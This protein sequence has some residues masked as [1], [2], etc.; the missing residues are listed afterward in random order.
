MALRAAGRRSHAPIRPRPLQLGPAHVGHVLGLT[1][2]IRRLDPAFVVAW[3]ARAVLATAL[4]GRAVAGRPSRPARRPR[5]HGNPRR[6]AA[7]ASAS[8]RPRT[9]SPTSSR[10]TRWCCI[11]AST[12]PASPRSRSPRALRTRLCLGALVGWKRPELALEIAALMPELRLT[13]AGATLPG[14]DGAL[15]A[16]AAQPGRPTRGP[17]HDRPRRRRAGP[18]SPPPTSCST[19]PTPSPTA[20][21]SSRRWPRA[22]R[23][24]PR[25][26]RARSRSSRTAR[27]VSTRPATP[28]AAVE[29]LRAVLADAAR[30]RG[31]PPP[32]RERLRRRR[33]RRAAW[34]ALLAVTFA[35]VIVLHESRAELA[36]LLD[37]LHSTRAAARR[38]RHRPRR[39]RGRNSRENTAR[40]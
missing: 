31:R 10:R 29:A 25:P 26:R 11:P 3:G 33:L 13:L 21:P 1:R 9:R 35:A 28:Q 4:A 8:L 39:R 12:S 14:D 37:S 22:A 19:A 18:R 27:A 16:E 20:W 6:D 32:R 15:E 24:S 30:A 34:R 5:A 2:D 40:R 7:R 38:R 23:S 36:L 17:G